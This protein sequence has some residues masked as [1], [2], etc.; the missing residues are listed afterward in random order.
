[1]VKTFLIASLAV[2]FVWIG[3][4]T[5]CR[6]LPS[7]FSSTPASLLVLAR[8]HRHHHHYWHWRWSRSPPLWY[9]APAIGTH[10]MP[11][12]GYGAPET[13]SSQ[14]PTPPAATVPE[15]PQGGPLSGKQETASQRPVDPVGGPASQIGALT[16][17]PG[18]H[19]AV[20]RPAAGQLIPMNRRRWVRAF[21]REASELELANGATQCRLARRPPGS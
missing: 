13:G 18:C 16:P 3:P 10:M 12:P 15:L 20:P 5:P 8:H 19:T 11:L 14:A 1:V 21:D 2:V 7:G 17:F 9:G 6:A 4:T